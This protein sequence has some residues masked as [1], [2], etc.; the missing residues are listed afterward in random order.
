MVEAFVVKVVEVCAKLR[1]SHEIILVNDGS[2]DKSW[3]ILESL[4]YKYSNLLCVNLDRNYGQHRA[5]LVGL[6]ECNGKRVIVIDSDLEENPE[7][8]INLYESSQSSTDPIQIVRTKLIKRSFFYR[9]FRYFFYKVFS[10]LTDFDFRVGV[11]NYGIYSQ[12]LIAQIRLDNSTY[13]FFPALV[14]KYSEKIQ[15]IN[16]DQSFSIPTKSTY[17]LKK[18]M[19]HASLV[20]VSNSKKPL[21]HL[22][23]IGFIASIASFLYGVYIL[24]RYLMFG[25]APSGWTSLATV[26]SIGFSLIIL[27]LGVIAIYLASFM[28][29]FSSVP[30]ASVKHKLRSEIL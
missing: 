30:K 25:S 5:V 14:H 17:K 12:E 3:E 28:D 2:T 29:H 1:I 27:S 4:I 24:L 18:L 8:I 15:Y 23:S 7:L 9:I 13:P 6:N 11:S 26:M 20:I 22:A 10:W 19:R 16:V 21:Y